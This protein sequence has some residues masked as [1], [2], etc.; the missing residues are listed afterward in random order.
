[1]SARR[2]KQKT[3]FPLVFLGLFLIGIAFIFSLNSLADPLPK[4]EETNTE[5]ISMKNLLIA[6]LLT[7]KNCKRATG[8]YQVSLLDRQSLNQI[9]VKVL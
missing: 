8:F 1:M 3:R 4:E 2:K 7:H 6:S 5:A 9:G